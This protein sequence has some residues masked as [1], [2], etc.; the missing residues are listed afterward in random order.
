MKN[1]RDVMLAINKVKKQ[2]KDH[3]KEVY[4]QN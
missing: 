3:C 1:E 2:K 4:T